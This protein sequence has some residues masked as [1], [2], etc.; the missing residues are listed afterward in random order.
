MFEAEV[1]DKEEEEEVGVVGVLG[2]DGM[3]PGR[4]SSSPSKL[5]NIF[6]FSLI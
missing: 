1:E 5:K 4:V 6:F 2:V 3:S